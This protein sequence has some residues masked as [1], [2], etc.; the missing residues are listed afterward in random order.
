MAVCETCLLRWDAEDEAA[1]IPVNLD[2]D[3]SDLYDEDECPI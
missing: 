3:D 1:G 2:D